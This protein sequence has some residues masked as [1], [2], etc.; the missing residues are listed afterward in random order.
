MGRVD[1]KRKITVGGAPILPDLSDLSDMSDSA[2]PDTHAPSERFPVPGGLVNRKRKI[3]VGTAHS[4]SRFTVLKNKP[5]P[6][7]ILNCLIFKSLI[8]P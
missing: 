3:T 4:R 5:P 2:A 6:G 1:R 7:Q 8:Y